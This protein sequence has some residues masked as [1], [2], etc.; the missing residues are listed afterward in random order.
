M[1]NLST[2]F[3]LSLLVLMGCSVSVQ[4]YDFQ[5]HGTD[6][7]NTSSNFKYIQTNVTGKAKTT[8][9]PKKWRKNQKKEPNG[10]ISSA[11]ANLYEM[12]PLGPNQALANVSIDVIETTK[13]KPTGF[14]GTVVA[15]AITIEVV[16][17]AD[18]IEY[19]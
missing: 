19:Y 1:K 6:P 14:S 5:Y 7:I 3:F 16:V 13:G 11:K 18:I 4:T 9:F 12:Y 2:L 8:Y 10:L 17:S 15:D